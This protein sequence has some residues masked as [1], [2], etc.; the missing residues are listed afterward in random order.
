MSATDYRNPLDGIELDAPDGWH[1][2]G[3]ASGTDYYTVT[4][5]TDQVLYQDG[6]FGWSAQMY[7]DRSPSDPQKHHVEFV[8]FTRLKQNGDLEYGYPSHTAT[9]ETAQDAADYLSSTAAELR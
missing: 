2:G 4:M 5:H 8:Q 1:L 3:G 6:E 7:W 9:F